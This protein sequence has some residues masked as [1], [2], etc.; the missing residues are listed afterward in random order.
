MLV[1]LIYL[2]I[3]YMI[4]KLSDPF[5]AL[6]QVFAWLFGGLFYLIYGVCYGMY[7]YIQILKDYKLDEGSQ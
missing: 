2:R 7:Y 3:F 5:D 4:I 1:P 6:Y